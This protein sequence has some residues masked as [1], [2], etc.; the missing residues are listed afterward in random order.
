[1]YINACDIPFICVLI[2]LSFIYKQY[3]HM[4]KYNQKML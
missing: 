1:M 2:L 4:Q 3:M